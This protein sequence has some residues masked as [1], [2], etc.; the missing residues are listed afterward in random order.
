MGVEDVEMLAGT[1][2]CLPFERLGDEL[3]CL[4]MVDFGGVSP[5]GPIDDADYFAT[6]R[7]VRLVPI[8]LL[9][10]LTI[11]GGIDGTFEVP[12]VLEVGETEGVEDSSV[13][14]FRVDN[15][16]FPVV[17]A[18]TFLDGLLEHVAILVFEAR[19]RDNSQSFP[20]PVAESRNQRRRNE[21]LP[22]YD[23]TLD[24]VAPAQSQGR[25][26]S[27]ECLFECLRS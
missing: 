21:T 25:V 12:G 11:R 3:R 17:G 19:I 13:K 23:P 15:R 6:E 9:L 5:R 22:L 8:P 7:L 27:A 2:G 10:R 16:T 18:L 26:V 20:F 14:V 4:P 24:R 1:L